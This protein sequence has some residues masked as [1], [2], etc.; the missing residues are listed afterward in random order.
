MNIYP[1]IPLAKPQLGNDPGTWAHKTIE[2]RFKQ[3]LQRVLDNNNF[4]SEGATAISRLMD[5]IPSC[6]IRILQD[7]NAPDKSSWDEYVTPFLGMNWFQ[8]PWF[9]TEHYFY[10]RIMEAINYFAKPGIHKIDPFKY[11]KKLGLELNRKAIE[12]M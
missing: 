4:D 8:P 1:K 11:P 3:I 12:A 10:R 6:P 2:T 9:F 5:D 7:Q